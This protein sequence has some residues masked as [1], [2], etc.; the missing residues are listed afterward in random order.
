MLE[1]FLEVDYTDVIQII[2]QERNVVSDVRT[3]STNAQPIHCLDICHRVPPGSGALQRYWSCRGY[4]SCGRHAMG[5]MGRELGELLG[6][7][8]EPLEV[9]ELSGVLEVQ[10][11]L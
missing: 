1:T 9:W 10:E 5:I 4:R 7:L 2:S 6:Q 8:Q 3:V 11:L